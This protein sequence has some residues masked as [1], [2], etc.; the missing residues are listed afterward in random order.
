MPNAPAV[1]VI[2]PM[3]NVEKYIVETLESLLAQTF[4]DFEVIVVNDCS[5]DKSRAIAKSYLE[6]F[7]GRM[8]LF[9]NEK[10]SGPSAS[11]NN[12]LRRATGE[13]VFFMDADDMLL[14]NGLEEIYSF[15]TDYGVDFINCTSNYRLSADSQEA[16]F[17]RHVRK[18]VPA[19]MIEENM[20]R[21]IEL[22]I[23]LKILWAPWRRFSRR[24]FLL[25]NELFFL[26]N[27]RFAE[28][29]IW[30]YGMF[31]CAKK[32]LQ[33]PRPYI[34]YRMSENS[35]SS[36]KTTEMENITLSLV[37]LICGIK[38]IDNIMSRMEYFKRNPQSRFDVLKSLVIMFFEMAS[39]YSVEVK[40]HEIYH[41]IM[42]QF[43]ESL[44]DN[45]VLIAQ[46]ITYIDTHKKYIAELEEQLKA[47]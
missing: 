8:K 26:E 37:P 44:G 38:W 27:I 21:I 14:L 15:A 3:Y 43:G 35:L 9:D 20:E 46:L 32:I 30:S 40:P 39:K 12:G 13:Y 24:K 4:Q 17:Q 22:I 33:L 31:L 23:R 1:S 19:I 34:F 18:F 41:E 11:R 45:D 42:Q 25:E 16:I 6:K 2:I 29:R 28:D 47:K 7:G 10:N 5:T 36:P